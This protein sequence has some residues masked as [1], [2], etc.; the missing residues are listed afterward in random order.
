[1]FEFDD[2]LVLRKRAVQILKISDRTER[3]KRQSGDPW[4]PHLRI[5]SK[6]YYRRSG[7]AEYLQRQE[8]LAA[9]EEKSD[10]SEGEATGH[11]PGPWP[12]CGATGR[13][14]K[15][16]EHVCGGGA[17]QLGDTADDTLH[18]GDRLS[19]YPDHSELA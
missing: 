15:G 19:S 17:S 7:I 3:R 4:P 16:R 18:L 2:D 6:V 8:A 10:Q 14:S 12:E 1:M 5:G 13:G 9:K 11:H